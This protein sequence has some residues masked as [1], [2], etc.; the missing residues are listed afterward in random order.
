VTR[1][2]RGPYLKFS[3]VPRENLHKT[4]EV[5]KTRLPETETERLL[6]R[7]FGQEDLDDLAAILVK[8]EVMRYLGLRGEPMRRE[9]TD[10]ALLSMISHWRRKGF[11]RWAA[12]EKAT[13]RLIGFAGLRSFGRRPELVYLLDS[14]YWGRGLAT[15]MA[16]ECLRFGF[17]EKAFGEVVAFARPGNVA[18]RRV[19][20]KIGMRYEGRG[21]F[22]RLLREAGE[23]AGGGDG[24]DF[25]VSRYSAGLRDYLRR[26]TGLETRVPGGPAAAQGL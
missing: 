16:Q 7:Q 8:A 24:K 3:A 18:S 26:G 6:L 1:N 11:G 9:E 10:K 5:S 19:L 12:E 4:S 25:Q 20:E 23:G 17:R 21:E 22:F 14:P 15:E 13:G 2:W